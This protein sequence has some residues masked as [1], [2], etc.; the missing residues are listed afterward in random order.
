MPVSD[1][2]PILYTF[3]RCPYAMR[4][5]MALYKSEQACAVREV[6]LRDK[7]AEMLAQSAKGT[8]PV[9]VLTD[10]TVFDES[11]DIM[12]WALNRCDPE[13]WLSPAHGTP[14]EVLALIS[15][16]DGPFKDHL[17][18]YKYSTRYQDTDPIVHRE[19]G[20]Q[21]LEILNGRLAAS[22][23]LFG[24]HISLAD[25]AIFPFVRQ[26]AKSGSGLV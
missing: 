14:D 17:D 4:A 10:G 26:F 16:N 11:L 2:L 20:V 21:F 24:D 1:P 15:R 7:P 13:N 8:V 25:I 23:F 18:R 5:R 19:Q 22:T 6:L 9:L 12:R 3:R